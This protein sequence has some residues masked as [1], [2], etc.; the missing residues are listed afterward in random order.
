M[1]TNKHYIF[2]HSTYW[3]DNGCD[4]CE[5][6]KWDL[7]E[8]VSHPLFSNSITQDDCLLDIIGELDSEYCQMLYELDYSTKPACE[9]LAERGITWEFVYGGD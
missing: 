3:T 5:P 8:C 2:K 4:C 7:Y 9:W 1:N 6:D